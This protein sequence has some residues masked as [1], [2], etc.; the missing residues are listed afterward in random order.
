MAKVK[1]NDWTKKL[2]L[3]YR[4]YAR[5]GRD[6]GYDFLSMSKLLQEL[7][8][9]VTVEERERVFQRITPDEAYN[10]EAEGY[11]V[12]RARAS[13]PKLC[14]YRQAYVFNEKDS[15]TPLLDIYSD[16]ENKLSKTHKTFTSVQIIDTLFTDISAV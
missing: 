1:S 14:I 8:P 12:I 7:H 16:I 3:E 9:Q 4:I 10:Y 13:D 6:P 15:T 2:V 11:L 5:Q